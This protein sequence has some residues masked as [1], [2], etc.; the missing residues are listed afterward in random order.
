MVQ[1]LF[2]ICN[3]NQRLKIM[4]KL[5]PNVCDIAKN[6]QGTHTIQSFIALFVSD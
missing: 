5:T 2:T 1:K 6:K 4:R 3:V